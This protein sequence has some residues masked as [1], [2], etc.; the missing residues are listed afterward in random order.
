MIQ[1]NWVNLLQFFLTTVYIHSK[2]FVLTQR[3]LLVF[4]MWVIYI[5]EPHDISSHVTLK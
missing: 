2:V 4:K 5:F 1:L 3:F